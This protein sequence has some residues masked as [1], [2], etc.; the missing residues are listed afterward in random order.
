M[1]SFRVRC[2]SVLRS[3]RLRC[4]DRLGRWGAELL[5][6]E[7]ACR[8]IDG[9]Q[10]SSATCSLRELPTPMYPVGPPAGHFWESWVFTLC[11][12]SQARQRER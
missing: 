5:P 6:S 2:A 8:A 9:F 7:R 12:L 3:C 11:A 4:V 1:V 10:L